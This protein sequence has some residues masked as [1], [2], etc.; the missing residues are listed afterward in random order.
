MN[1]FEVLKLDPT[2][3]DEEIVAQAARLKQ[4]AATDA[5]QAAIQQAVQ[6][7]M[8]HPEARRLHV[9]LSHPRP[10]HTSAALERFIA[11]FR[12]PPVSTATPAPCPELDREEFDRLLR[13]AAAEELDLK[14]E[15]FE[16]LDPVDP[17]DVRRQ[18][19][20]AVWQS[21]IFDP[22]G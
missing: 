2:A 15:P 1:P 5:E 4:R 19:A 17:D 6:A 14:P 21:L 8:S 16:P 22:R 9:L 18:A 20:E 7:L 13:A 10:T 11:A 12:R 3:T